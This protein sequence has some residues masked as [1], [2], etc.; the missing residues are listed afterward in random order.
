MF[1]KE[2][3]R[4]AMSNLA[5]ANPGKQDGADGAPGSTTTGGPPPET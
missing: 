1:E 2:T 4:V 5:E 3:T